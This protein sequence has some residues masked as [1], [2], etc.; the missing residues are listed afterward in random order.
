M[1]PANYNS[2]NW[3]NNYTTL[4]IQATSGSTTKTASFAVCGGGASKPKPIYKE[5]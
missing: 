4:K 3:K 2:M 1:S 5:I